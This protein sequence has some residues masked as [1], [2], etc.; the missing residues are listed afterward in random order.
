MTDATFDPQPC[1]DC[2]ARP[3]TQVGGHPWLCNTHFWERLGRET[4][5]LVR[6][7][8]AEAKDQGARRRI[9]HYEA[10]FSDG[11]EEAARKV[12]ELR[13]KLGIGVDAACFAREIRALD[14][15]LDAPAPKET[16]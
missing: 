10:G 12:E 11:I 16:P 2:G 14:A 1:A 6:A 4:I 3:A 5:A 7:V 13:A 15:P 8:E 9:T